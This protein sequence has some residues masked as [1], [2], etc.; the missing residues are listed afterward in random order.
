MIQIRRVGSEFP[1]WDGVLS[2]ILAAFAVWLG[3]PASL[4]LLGAFVWYIG[5]YQIRPEELHDVA[6]YINRDIL[7][8]R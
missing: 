6:S 5:R 4:P 3:N 8:L 7:P 2:L 1:D